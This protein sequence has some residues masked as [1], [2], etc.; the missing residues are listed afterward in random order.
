MIIRTDSIKSALRLTIVL[1]VLK[2]HGTDA[3]VSQ[4]VNRQKWPCQSQLMRI[5]LAVSIMG[6]L[7][8]TVLGTTINPVPDL[9]EHPLFYTGPDWYLKQSK[10]LIYHSQLVKAKKQLNEQVT[11]WKR[12]LTNDNLILTSMLNN[13]F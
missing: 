4:S 10:K 5:C 2:N 6:L 1:C 11:S 12:Q 3:F 9:P 8:L 13:N 7:C